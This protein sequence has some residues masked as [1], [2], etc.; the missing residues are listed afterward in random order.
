[1]DSN[2]ELDLIKEFWDSGILKIERYELNGVQHGIQR[3][4]CEDGSLLS[5]C[6]FVHGKLHGVARLF[7]ETGLAYIDE[8]FENGV[9]HGEYISRWSSGGLKEHGF[10]IHGEPQ[11]GYRYYR[12]DGSLRRQV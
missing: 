1:M 7:T 9:R 10:Y 3:R 11:P 4:W 6:T 12:E 5:E 8:N 2:E